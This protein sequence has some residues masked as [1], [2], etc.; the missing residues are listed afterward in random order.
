MPGKCGC[1]KQNGSQSGFSLVEVI[2]SMLLLLFV[3]LSFVPLYSFVHKNLLSNRVKMMAYNL[4]KDRIEQIRSMRYNEVGTYPVDA[5][6]NPLLDEHGVPYRGDPDGDI[7]HVFF[8]TDNG[9]QFRIETSI[10]WVDDYM[11][12]VGQ[13]PESPDFNPKTFDPLGAD[14]KKV[15]VTVSSPSLPQGVTQTIDLRTISSLEGE[16]QAFQGGNILVK[17]VHGW[18]TTG[19]PALPAPSIDIYLEDGPSA[20]MWSPTDAKFGKALFVALDEGDY[21]VRADGGAAGMM[22]RPVQDSSSVSV[23]VIQKATKNAIFEADIPCRLSVELRD[24]V[25]PDDPVT[26][27]ATLYLSWPLDMKALGYEEHTVPAGDCQLAD[28]GDIWPVG[29]GYSGNYDLLVQAPGYRDYR[30]RNDHG[31]VWDGTFSEPGATRGL[32]LNLVPLPSVT[33]T[34]SE[35]GSGI[36]GA[37]VAWFT[38]TYTY[39]GSN[40][41]GP[42]ASPIEDGDWVT[43]GSAGIAYLPDD[44]MADSA[45]KPASPVPGSTYTCYGVQVSAAGYRDEGTGLDYKTVGPAFWVSGTQQMPVS[46]D[47]QINNKVRTYSVSLDPVPESP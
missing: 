16:E 27:G 25:N 2:V 13:D 31:D 4:A 15:V 44:R 30:L 41:T 18:N 45:P 23:S 42:V 20:P 33:V 11:N 29:A 34:S 37:T 35:S 26:T 36:E 28:F 19:G 8:K 24:N 3:I 46:G 6:G 5:D 22:I 39:D 43:T 38:V 32:V 40:W 9:I 7:P 1:F 17:T 14:Y 47:D 10:T 21:N 12:G